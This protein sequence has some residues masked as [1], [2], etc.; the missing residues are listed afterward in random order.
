[1][2]SGQSA[3]GRAGHKT[4]LALDH[5]LAAHPV[6]TAA[7][8]LKPPVGLEAG[9]KQWL[10]DEPY[11][12]TVLGHG[13]DGVTPVHIF[14]EDEGPWYAM[15]NSRGEFNRTFQTARRTRG[16]YRVRVQGATRPCF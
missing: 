9:T 3:D 15:A 8:E 10:G 6:R 14:F 2:A 16:V 11:Q 4:L 1:M 13:F 5:A 12:L 7:I